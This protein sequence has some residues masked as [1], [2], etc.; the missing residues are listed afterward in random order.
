MQSI[1]AENPHLTSSNSEHDLRGKAAHEVWESIAATDEGHLPSSST[2][3]PPLTS[4]LGLS[5]VAFNLSGELVR[6]PPYLPSW[7]ISETTIV[8]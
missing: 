2:P 8:F 4:G 3:A 5:G 7:F 6:D 1:N